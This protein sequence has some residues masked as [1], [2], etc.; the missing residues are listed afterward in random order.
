MEWIKEVWCGLTKGHEWESN[1]ITEGTWCEVN[2]W[3]K[4]CG[5]PKTK[6]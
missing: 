4:H 3:C 5:K 2:S 1:G 6:Y